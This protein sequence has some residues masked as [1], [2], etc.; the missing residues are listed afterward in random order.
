MLN[1]KLT[2]PVKI[3]IDQGRSWTAAPPSADGLDLTDLV[4]GCFQYWIR[5]EAAARDLADSGLTMRTV[6]QTNQALIPHLHDG[7]N[8][9]SFSAG[10]QAFVSAGPN[11]PQAEAHL[12]DGKFGSPTVTLELAAPRHEKAVRVFAMAHMASG[13]PPSDTIYQIDS[14]TD[15]GKTW[16]PVVK[17]WKILRRGD[18]P[19]DFWSQSMCYGDMALD[20][21]A[22]AVRLRFTNNSKKSV[23]R[24]EAHLV[25]EPRSSGPVEIAFAWKENGGELKKE[26]RLYPGTPGKEDASWELKAGD[27]VETVWVEYRAK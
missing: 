25:Y 21:V 15:E 20:R 14:S 26:S 10:G 19:D 23:N 6:C 22:G 8:R 4:K 17:D 1:G 18:E 2:C 11:A 12:V 9:I 27:N 7:K 3:S 5:F 16:Q 13:S 24:A